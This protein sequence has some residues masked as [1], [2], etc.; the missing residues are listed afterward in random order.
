MLDRKTL[1][2]AANLIVILIALMQS[3]VNASPNGLNQIPIA[4]VY[5]DGGFA[6]SYSLSNLGG[7]QSFL[8]TQ[9]GLYNIAEVGVDY[10]MSPAD[11]SAFLLNGK[12]L[13]LHKPG[14]LPDVAVGFENLATH[15][16]T[17]PYLVATTQPSLFGFSLGAIRPA[18]QTFEGMGGVSYN[19]SK[20]LQIVADT[21]TGRSN[22]TT[23]GVIDN[24][25]PMIQVNVAYAQ[26]NSGEAG[27]PGYIFN[28]T[29]IFHLKGGGISHGKDLSKKGGVIQTPQGNAGGGSGQGNSSAG[30]QGK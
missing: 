21:I 16:Q 15:R 9:Y 23:L 8:T 5:G 17:E 24:V 12:L 6:S 7:S 11:Q 3:C 1:T 26:P 28:V 22:F 18:G 29:Y 20:T 27:G 4:K 19:A 2:T 13:L 25:T 14:N 10:Q 30:G